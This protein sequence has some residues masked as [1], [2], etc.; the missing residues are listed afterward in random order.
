MSAMTV[1]HDQA[2]PILV[3]IVRGDMVESFHR[4]AV[5]IAD[6]AGRIARSL[7]DVDRLVYPRSALKPIQALPLIETG[8]ADG[9]ALGE[10]ELALACASHRGEPFHVAAVAA[11]LARIGLGEADL[12]CGVHP[13]RHEPSYRALLCAGGA[14]SQLHNN[15][16]GKHAGFL[17]TARWLREP[18][19]FY[20]EPDH[21]VQQRVARTIGDM[22]GL[23]LARAPRGRDGCGI[24][25]IALPLGALAAAMARLADPSRLGEHRRA[26]AK[27]LLDAMAALPLMVDGTSGMT[28]AVMTAARASVC[29]KPG[30]EG[31]FCAALPALGLGVALKI[32]DGGGRAAEL[33][34]A[35]VLDRLGCFT[36]EQREALARFLAPPLNTVAGREAGR[37]QP[38]AALRSF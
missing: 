12:E 37:L 34:M 23:D 33:A 30:A 9:F 25:V 15:C 26:A 29:L 20:I 8:A 28:A 22:A 16:S 2:S 32:D 10:A 24:P 36:P 21:P 35:A 17:A 19:R 14:P 1:Q 31:V 27:R 11:W 18:T 4:G 38:A 6:A 7:G 5:A 13:P 3:E